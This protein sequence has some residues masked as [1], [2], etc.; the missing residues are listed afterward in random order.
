MRAILSNGRLTYEVDIH[1]VTVADSAGGKKGALARRKVGS[2]G[3]T[4]MYLI[5]YSKWPSPNRPSTRQLPPP[6]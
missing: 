4:Y 5:C 6:A 1:E 3:P 2:D